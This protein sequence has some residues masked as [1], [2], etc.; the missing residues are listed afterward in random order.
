MIYRWAKRL[1]SIQTP[2]TAFP[3]AGGDPAVESEDSHQLDGALVAA[4][5]AS[6]W[7]LLQSLRSAGGSGSFVYLD[8][9]VI[10]YGPIFLVALMG[11]FLVRPQAP[12]RSIAA[13]FA[14]FVLLAVLMGS[15]WVALGRHSVTGVV[16]I[17]VLAWSTLFALVALVTALL[18]TVSWAAALHQLSTPRTAIN[19]H[20]RAF[21]LMCVA[22]ILFA[23]LIGA[24]R[25]LSIPLIGS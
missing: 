14:S 22:L 15:V 12:V 8:R 7:V 9:T 20:A 10:T 25:A 19:D 24:H 21:R 17:D 16:A 23:A 3:A 5:I 2:A 1:E 18:C 13:H 11:A 6:L 4:S